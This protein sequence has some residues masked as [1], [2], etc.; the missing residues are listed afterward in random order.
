MTC[1][2]KEEF[3]LNHHVL[4]IPSRFRAQPR[5]IRPRFLQLWHLSHQF[6]V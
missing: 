2:A 1:D 3:N 6:V 5:P 4:N